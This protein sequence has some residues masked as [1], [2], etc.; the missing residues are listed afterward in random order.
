[1]LD[2]QT[3]KKMTGI[4]RLAKLAIGCDYALRKLQQMQTLED[5]KKKQVPQFKIKRA[6]SCYT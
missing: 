4:I 2:E 6:R 3:H 1:M 5:E